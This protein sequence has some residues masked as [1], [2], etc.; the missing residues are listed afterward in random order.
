VKAW[1]SPFSVV[2]QAQTAVE[3]FKVRTSYKSSRTILK[4][5]NIALIPTPLKYSIAAR[6]P[7]ANVLTFGQLPLAS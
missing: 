7:V 3:G 6:Q 2:G 5:K 4:I 1:K